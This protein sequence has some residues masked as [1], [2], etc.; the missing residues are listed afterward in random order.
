MFAGP[1]ESSG[2]VQDWV[3]DRKQKRVY[4]AAKA[5]VRDRGNEIWEAN[6]ASVL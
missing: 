1:S 3:V 2:I 5:G 4:E 6:C